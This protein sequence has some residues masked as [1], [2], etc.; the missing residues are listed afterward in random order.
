MTETPLVSIC[1]PTFNRA[2]LIWRTLESCINQTYKN[3]EI[4]VSDNASTDNTK[5]V[6]L[7]YAHRDRRVKYFRN[8]TNIGSGNNYLKSVEHA[9]GYFAQTLGSDDWLSRN[10]VEECVQNFLINPGAAAILT[11]TIT[12]ELKKNNHLR[13]TDENPLGP[14][15]YSADWFFKNFY[16]HPYLGGKGFLSLMRREDLVQSLKT[17]ILR[18]TSLIDR[19][20]FFEVIDGTIFFGVLIKY[21][22]FIVA[23]DAAYITLLNKN[24]AVGL[25]GG[26]FKDFDG[27]LRYTLAIRRAFEAIYAS[28]QKLIKY[29]RRMSFFMSLSFIANTFLDLLKTKAGPREWKRRYIKIN[30]VFL[31][32]YTGRE[33]LTLAFLTLPYFLIRVP[34]RL[35]RLFL[36]KPTFVPKRN[37][38][39]ANDFRFIAE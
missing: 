21:D 36:P 25:K 28:F 29:K 1:I 31:E 16:N 20:D 12:F 11:N 17:E 10:Y 8:E 5:T 9:S 30:A 37:Y 38:F 18:P 27:R 32:A 6:V 39:L 13:F 2:D 14:G 4:I 24:D 34:S 22:Y 23:K 3:I 15:K 7:D 35:K 19:G 26:F 33:K